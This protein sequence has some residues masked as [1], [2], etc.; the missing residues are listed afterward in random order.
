MKS[1]FQ[2]SI[3][4][5]FLNEEKTPLIRFFLWQKFRFLWTRRERIH[6][7]MLD[8]VH[9]AGTQVYHLMIDKYDNGRLRL[10][11]D[12]GGFLTQLRKRKVLKT[13]RIFLATLLLPGMSKCAE[14]PIEIILKLAQ[15]RRQ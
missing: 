13:W 15:Y 2:I 10:T 11:D 8:A 4:F 9:G 7:S 14:V 12:T 6:S 5:K 1:L 3:L